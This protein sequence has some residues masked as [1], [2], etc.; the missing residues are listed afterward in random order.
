MDY[1]KLRGRIIEK[2][3]TCERFAEA[4]GMQ[5]S[6][7]SLKLSATRPW[8]HNEIILACQL[9]DILG[10]DVSEYFFAELAYN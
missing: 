5:P 6:L 3:N 10:S 9:L 4:M 1:S 2:Y 8:K 7:L